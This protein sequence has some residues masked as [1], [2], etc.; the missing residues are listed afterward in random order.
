[1]HRHQETPRRIRVA[2]HLKHQISQIVLTE[3]EDP[4][5]AFVTITGVEVSADLRH[6]KVYFSLIGSEEARQAC[7]RGLM[8]ARGFIKRELAK[9]VRLRYMPE[10]TFLHDH[11]L[12]HGARIEALLKSL[13]PQEEAAQEDPSPPKIVP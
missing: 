13:H 4:R 11:S 10:L 8:R 12:E 6:A 2:E 3:V 7:H 9:R 5:V 1:M